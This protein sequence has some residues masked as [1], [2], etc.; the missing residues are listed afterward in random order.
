MKADIRQYINLHHS[1]IE[2]R[3][4]LDA[5]LQAIDEALSGLGGLAEVK[6]KTTRRGKRPGPAKKSRVGAAVVRRVSAATG[7]QKRARNKLSLRE[8]VTQVTT[9]NPMS[10]SEILAAIK[11]LGYRFTA[12]NPVNSLNTVLY[13]H[14]Q[15]K[16]VK[17]KFSAK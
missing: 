1:L 3:A 13:S 7:G 8:A 6:M 11:K 17:G 12:K 15:F 14:Q 9:N 16:N 2:E 10:K 5:R 4:T